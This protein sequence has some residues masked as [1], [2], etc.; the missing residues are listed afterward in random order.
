MTNK[1]NQLTDLTYIQW[2][3]KEEWSLTQAVYL[4]HGLVPPDSTVTNSVLVKEFPDAEKM[5]QNLPKSN[6]ELFREC[7]ENWALLAMADNME[8]TDCWMAIFPQCIKDDFEYICG[9][10]PDYRRFIQLFVSDTATRLGKLAEYVLNMGGN[11]VANPPMQFNNI[12]EDMN[13]A[14]GINTK[15]FDKLAN[16]LVSPQQFMNECPHHYFSRESQ[17]LQWVNWRNN[18]PELAASL[19]DFNETQTEK[20][21]QIKHNAIAPVAAHI[22]GGEVRKESKDK[23]IRRD[24]VTSNIH[25]YLG[26]CAKEETFSPN[27][28]G[29]WRFLNTIFELHTDGYLIWYTGGGEPKHLTKKLLSGRFNTALK[30]YQAK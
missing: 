14:L 15:E 2:V 18:H 23:R 26:N 10:I 19:E 4:L 3:E 20:Q 29:C 8:V 11:A 25:V 17:C 30:D 21:T 5:F 16:T 24:Q 28:D 12:L 7:P 6:Q 13:T 22:N 1:Q 27:T 9:K